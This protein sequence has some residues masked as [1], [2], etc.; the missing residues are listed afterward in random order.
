MNRKLLI[1]I[2]LSFGICFFLTNNTQSINTSVNYK[3]DPEDLKSFDTG[4]LFFDIFFNNLL[5]GFMLSVFGFFTGGILT[6]ILIFW[7]GYLLAM[8][9]Y[10]AFKILPLH[11]IFYFSKH[12]PLE[13]LA[14]IFLAEIGLEG[15]NFFKKILMKE[16]FS[17][18]PLLYCRKIIL[19]VS[20]LLIA[21][22][23]ETI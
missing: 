7:N 21:A 1:L 2:I 19:S 20:L 6:S 3:I 11:E 12:I 10:S 15:F 5:L 17:F 14:F 16:E 4:I 9:F 13:I 23:L 18:Y 8:I 22:F